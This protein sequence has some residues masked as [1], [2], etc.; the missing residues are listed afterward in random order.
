MILTMLGQI[1]TPVTRFPK[2]S[3]VVRSSPPHAPMMSVLGPGANCRGRVRC[4][5]I[6]FLAGIR[7]NGNPLKNNDD[8]LP[9]DFVT[10]I[11]AMGSQRE[12]RMEFDFLKTGFTA[13]RC[14]A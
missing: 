3:A 7:E 8:G 13:G 14:S 10:S 2:F 12:M 5:L 9:K 4:Q 6:L 11:R 1:S